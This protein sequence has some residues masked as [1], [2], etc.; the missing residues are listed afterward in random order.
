MIGGPTGRPGAA[1][2][3]IQMVGAQAARRFLVAVADV[4]EEVFTRPPWREPAVRARGVAARLLTDSRQPGFVLALAGEGEEVCG[5][6]YGHR[7]STL[8]RLASRPAGDDFTL[9]ELAVLPGLRGRGLGAALHDTLLEAAGDR[10][11]WL[12]THP[13]ATAA[14]GL[15]RSRGWRV[16]ALHNACGQTRLIMRK[17]RG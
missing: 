12:A 10:P 8:A 7:C 14:L 11:R 13:A 2:P 16:I 3:H 5:F 9:K 1:L 15:Y 4:G 17:A 6:S